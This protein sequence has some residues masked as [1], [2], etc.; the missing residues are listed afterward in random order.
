[1]LSSIQICIMQV[2]EGGD[3][4]ERTVRIFEEIIAEN[5]PNLVTYSSIFPRNSM[6]SQYDKLKEIHT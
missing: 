6:N 4:E 1:M 3:R 5:F 2:S